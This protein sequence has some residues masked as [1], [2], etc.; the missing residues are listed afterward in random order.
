[1][2]ISAKNAPKNPNEF[3]IG[4]EIIYQNAHQNSDDITI[5]SEEDLRFKEY[6]IIIPSPYVHFLE[7]LLSTA[8]GAFDFLE[9][10]IPFDHPISPTF[11]EQYGESIANSEFLIYIRMKL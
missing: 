3:T 10:T 9:R 11:V 5:G 6:P 1:M 7:K 8:S 4:R 2:R